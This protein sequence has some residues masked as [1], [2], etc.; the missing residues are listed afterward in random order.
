[1]HARQESLDLPVPASL[2]RRTESSESS[3]LDSTEAEASAARLGSDEA[4][5]APQGSAN[6]LGSA[7]TQG[8]PQGSPTGRAQ[9]RSG[10]AELE[11]VLEL[12][13][14]SS[15]ASS[16]SEGASAS[17]ALVVVRAAPAVLEHLADHA[18]RRLSGNA[19][20]E[21]SAHVAFVSGAHVDEPWREVVRYVD[22]AAAS[23]ASANVHSDDV[24]H[25]TASTRDVMAPRD[26]AERIAAARCAAILIVDPTMSSFGRA[27]L[28]NLAEI[29]SATVDDAATPN[30][31]GNGAP[32]LSVTRDSVTRDSARRTSPPVIVFTSNSNLAKS[33][34]LLP[35]GAQLTI[36]DVDARLEP[37][38]IR[39]W[40]ES[41]TR[42]FSRLPNLDRLDSLASWW[43]AASATPPDAV[44]PVPQVSSA[45]A[46]FL[47]RLALAGRA[48][49]L[50]ALSALDARESHVQELRSFGLVSFANDL[51]G[52][53]AEANVE[54]I[55]GRGFAQGDAT[56][57]SV[58][59]RALAEVFRGDPWATMRA[60][61]MRAAEL[62]AAELRA[63][64]MRAAE[65][66]ATETR[67]GHRLSGDEATMGLLTT[68][69]SITADS[70]IESM[71]MRAIASVVDSETRED[72]WRRYR[73][74]VVDLCPER[75]MADVASCL[76]TADL[77]LRIGD[78]DR[79]VEFS[80]LA[81]SAD[82]E[83]PDVLLTLGRA[84]AAT[85]DLTTAAITI[86]KAMQRSGEA[87]AAWAR[88][89]VEL[90]EV[91]YTTGELAEAS[92]LAD[93]GL[94]AAGSVS[95]RLAAR[96]VL[97]KILL[98]RSSYAEADLHFAGDACDAACAGESVAEL[99]ARLNRA[100]ALMSATRHD[101]ARAMLESVLELG[102]E[103]SEVK[104]VCFALGNLA[105]IAILQ[106]R[107]AEALALL[108]RTIDIVRRIGDKP[109]LALFITNLA[110]LRLR[111][112]LDRE[113]EQLLLF[114]RRVC[115]IT[116]PRF[117][118]FSLVSARIQLSRGRTVEAMRDI[119]TAMAGSGVSLSP[120]TKSGA[121]SSGLPEKEHRGW[122]G[123]LGLLVLECLRMAARAA[124]E[125]GDT[126][127]ANEFLDRA[128]H[129]NGTPRA[130]A[131]VVTLRAAC[132][133][134]SGESFADL[135][136]DA[137]TAARDAD[138]EELIR[139]AHLL[140][141]HAAVVD[142]DRRRAELHLDAAIALRNQVAESL[143]DWIKERYL[144]RH[145]L[146]ELSR[147][148]SARA[149]SARARLSS[150]QRDSSR[151]EA[152]TTRE[153]LPRDGLPRDGL[154]RDDARRA[155]RSRKI[156]GSDVAVRSLL[157]A[158]QK[159]GRSDTTVLIHGESGTGKELVAEALHEASPRASGPM[160]KVNCAALVETLLLSELF[161]HEKG[162]FTGA[163]GRR[164]GRFEAADGGTLF[165]DEI[166]DI[167]SR[168]QVALLRILQEKTFERVGGTTSIRSNVRV[169]CATHRDLKTLVAKGEFRE[170]LYYRLCGVVL[171][172][173][174]L[175]Q[176]LGDLGVVADALLRRIADER[177]DA[178]RT[179]SPSALQALKQHAW[180]GNVR[181]LEN[182]LRAASLFADGAQ[183]ELED[184]TE[185]VESLRSLAPDELGMAPANS[186]N[187][188]SR[189]STSARV[190]S[191]GPTSG[192]T[193]GP[194]TAPTSGPTT[195][196]SSQNGSAT[197]VAGTSFQSSPPSSGG[198]PAEVAYAHVRSGVSLS[199]M[200]KQIERDCIA[201]ALSETDGN[202]TRAATLLGM[203]R[204]R[205]SQ[206]VKQ[207]GL[208]SDGV[209]VEGGGGDGDGWA[210]DID[211]EGEE[212]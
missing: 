58:V 105:T 49:P 89:A 134:A 77:A 168:T 4:W 20:L 140:I 194:T 169:V 47:V 197:P 22:G 172:V 28:G 108:E 161:G 81:A 5:R 90:A 66:R 26:A 17:C 21:G 187:V 52:L 125:D 151:P 210:G 38:E 83:S 171:E 118:Q 51:V 209:G 175:R 101:E 79:A 65:M 85:G 11:A 129:E 174:S 202:I 179:L 181:E 205:L 136:D 150:E 139:E 82:S 142:D 100:I 176:R 14:R 158:I 92:E 147:L 74:L 32:G 29:K 130:K 7:T 96:N 1:M 2:A 141:H 138:D 113:A 44:A 50:S 146:L 71:A 6:T 16:A 196:R 195:A 211:D 69:S 3:L 102:E 23:G 104:A 160:V 132:A 183:I 99:R 190:S 207:Y 13:R 59:P 103:R 95:V 10:F 135:A 177:N 116:S 93:Q 122:S 189:S 37:C 86:K 184:F 192:P 144:A 73:A 109:R 123:L 25:A 46:R 178:P 63:A 163:A 155:S 88:A 48:W 60:A 35:V 70:S 152:L 204:P 9:R 97:G 112:G 126:R 31:V 193:S 180:P 121:A 33:G 127:R 42:N 201:R 76:R 62:R 191:G 40:W 12:V 170:D 110:E 57:L 159:V 61:E 36:I 182:A 198:S 188:A 72:L 75:K 185:N 173:P 68:D 199:D 27:V 55:V 115:G 91:R 145:E 212:A 34:A 67:T 78:V 39:A 120:E 137:L 164:R 43:R 87:T 167:S 30:S 208:G 166:G 124:L 148:E 157:A 162:A 149:E 114:G 84:T 54:T 64:E 56:D 18:M 117:A 19:V 156:V 24:S 153:G 154:P 106:H 128:T 107:Y 133:R 165:L 200:K 203:K 186:E 94:A 119:G 45:A 131:E 8:S 111:L 143:P 80:R 15:L 53:S 98:A 206:L 41:V